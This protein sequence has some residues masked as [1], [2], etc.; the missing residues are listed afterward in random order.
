M[1]FDEKGFDMSDTEMKR[2]IARSD[3]HQT[4][5]VVVMLDVVNEMQEVS[6]ISNRTARSRALEQAVWRLKKPVVDAIKGYDLR[7]INDLDSMPSLV[8]SGPAKA[9]KRLM[10]ENISFVTD[11]RVE[12]LPNEASWQIPH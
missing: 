3:P 8:V 6:K 11:P 1:D 10:S 9:W 2:I 5:V 12:L 4:L 7:V